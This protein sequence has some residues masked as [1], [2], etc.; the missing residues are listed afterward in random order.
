MNVLVTGGAGYIGAVVADHLLA[1]GHE[2]TVLD[3]LS[4]G[5][6]ELIPAQAKFVEGDIHD[7]ALLR[8]LLPSGFE[9]VMHFAAFIEAGESMTDPVKYFNNNVVGSEI[10]FSEVANSGISKIIFS[11][12]AAVYKSKDEPI[13]ETDII[14]PA[15]VYGQTKR[16]MEEM[17][18]WLNKTKGLNVC[19]FRYF[20]AAGAS[21]LES[22][23]KRGE[24]HQPE[25]HLI[26]NILKSILRGEGEFSIN[27]NDYPTPDGTCIRDYIHVDN[28]VS[29][30]ILRL[31]ALAENKF[32]LDIFNLGN[33]QG[34]SNREV[35]ETAKAITGSNLE[36][37]YGPRRE[38]DAARLVASSGKAKEVLGWQ[39]KHP[40]LKTIIESAWSWH[41]VKNS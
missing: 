35:A 26:P 40:D 31:Q 17:L 18:F 23:P 32:K 29:A 21:L 9:A 20:N 6:R 39:P 36:I 11:S 8:E 16:T 2:V 1:A 41:Q 7:R 14:Q 34:Y 3:N 24:Q 27:G 4:H 12:T 37:K 38:G 33:G 5:Y 30:Y 10:L 25:T 28:L 13:E 22:P 19:I 15:N